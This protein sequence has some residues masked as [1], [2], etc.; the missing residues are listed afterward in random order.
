MKNIVESLFE[1]KAL[2]ICPENKPFWYTSG[3]IGPY[4]VNTH[5]LYENENEANELLAFIDQNI[6]DKD[7]I[8][9]LIFDRVVLK[10]TSNEIFYSVMY[11]LATHV[12][13][14]V[15]LEEIDYVSGGE[16]R[17][18]FFSIL[19]SKLLNKPHVTIFKDQSVR[20]DDGEQSLEGKNVL[21]VADLINTASSYEKL[22][23]P[24]I[25]KAGGTIKWTTAVIDRDEGGKE[26]LNKLG[27]ELFA[28][29]CMN[30]E[31]FNKAYKQRLIN[32]NQL[33]LVQSYKENVEE[34]MNEFL[35]MHP[36]FMQNAL[37]DEDIKTRSRAIKCV[38]GCFYS[39]NDYLAEFAGQNG[40]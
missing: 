8:A 37:V 12:K 28:L 40:G 32:K 35:K 17:D 36:E 39:A 25:K 13:K 22:W 30:K 23:V 19:L 29:V 38:A 20:L 14:Y 31:L 21:H 11:E 16:R 10:H 9:K 24:A 6:K 1:T 3:K 27:I 7:N 4:Y 2:K 26:V 15:G 18:W 33:E 34:S 5:F